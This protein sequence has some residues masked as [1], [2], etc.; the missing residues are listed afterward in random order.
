MQAVVAAAAQAGAA[1][2][3]VDGGLDAGA[4]PIAVPPGGSVLLA[5]AL[6][7]G[8]PLAG[9]AQ[10]KRP[11]PLLVA[12]RGAALP[13]WTSAAIVS[14]EAYLDDGN[15]PR[16]VGL[17]PG[18]AGVPIDNRR[19]TE[20]PELSVLARERWITSRESTG[21]ALSLARLCAAAGFTPTVAFRSNNYDVVRQL[22]AASLGVAIVPALGH[23]PDDRILATPLDSPSAC[24]RVVALHR[25]ANSNPLLDD[26][27]T[28]LRQAVVAS[29]AQR[30][31]SNP[32]DSACHDA[33]GARFLDGPPLG[34]ASPAAK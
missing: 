18:S 2:H 26:V 10:G 13:Q 34:S 24:R 21:G 6:L 3:L 5:A 29:R 23:V 9:V 12:G 4:G 7:E 32:P 22:V 17:G 30:K 1:G 11:S 27:L 8:S 14:G 15:A 16:R 33:S 28:T 31:D 19:V 25:E 20:L